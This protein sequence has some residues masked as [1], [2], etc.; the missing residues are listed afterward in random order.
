MS[1]SKWWNEFTL[2][3]RWSVY[4]IIVAPP[5]NPIHNCEFFE[6]WAFLDGKVFFF[7]WG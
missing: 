6:Q 4:R 3:G 1:A 7:D 2:P 5:K